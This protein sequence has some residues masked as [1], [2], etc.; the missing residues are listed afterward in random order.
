MNQFYMQFRLRSAKKQPF[1]QL[2]SHIKYVFWF[3]LF[4]KGCVFWF[5]LFPKGCVLSKVYFFAILLSKVYIY[6]ETHEY[7]EIV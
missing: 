6:N 1:F 5:N 7:I 4:P 3:N 2:A